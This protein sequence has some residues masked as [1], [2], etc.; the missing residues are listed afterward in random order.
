[1]KA[2]WSDLGLQYTYCNLTVT[3]GK[4]VYDNDFDCDE[5]R[6]NDN[7]NCISCED[8]ICNVHCPGSG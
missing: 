5:E 4:P 2:W 1:M 6:D 8:L 7:D 3:A